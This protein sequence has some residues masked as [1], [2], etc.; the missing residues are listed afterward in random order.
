MSDR[1]TIRFAA[2]M[3]AATVEVISPDLQVVDR[4]ML[5]A[6]RSR[7]VDVPSEQSFLRVHLPS[8]RVVTLLD[9]GKLDREISMDRIRGV[10]TSARL[11]SA[12]TPVPF[13][14]LPEETSYAAVKQYARQRSQLPR[15]ADGAADTLPLSSHATATLTA[16][17]GFVQ[18]GESSNRGR[19]AHWDVGG[20]PGQEPLQLQIQH[21]ESTA[22][23]DLSIP[24]NTRVVWAR[25]DT[26]REKRG[27]AFNVRLTTSEPAAD[28]ILGY[29]QRGDLHSAEAMAEWVDEAQDM[30]MSK[31]ADPYAAA[32]GGY[33]LL[34]LKM[35]DKMRNWAR[36]L[37]DHFPFLSDGSIIWAWQ[38]IHQE[39]SREAEI[40]DYLLKATVIGPPVYAAGMA[41]LSDGL[42]LMG[43]DGRAALT[44]LLNDRDVLVPASPLTAFIRTGDVYTRSDDAP[45]VVFDI[46]F[47][48]AS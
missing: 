42:R 35:F 40:R 47:T 21:A 16:A 2:D 6:G 7:S 1:L 27:L 8:G 19:E 44:K 11:R 13:E 18:K 20:P 37:A 14:D 10:G 36:N 38:L 15:M 31:M 46:G 23:L 17:G 41:L 4:V 5:N 9:P 22:R 30:L 26:I 43:T 39:P 25:A 28:T 32:V 33:L 3:P 48:P 45:P 24:G 12:P 34:R 29:L